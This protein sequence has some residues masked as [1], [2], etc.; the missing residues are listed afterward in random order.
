M[1][2]RTCGGSQPSFRPH[3]FTVHPRLHLYTEWEPFESAAAEG[4]LKG[5]Q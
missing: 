2:A 4:I 3:P 1:A 5:V